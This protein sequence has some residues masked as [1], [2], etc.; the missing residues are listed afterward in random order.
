MEEFNRIIDLL[1][2]P[3]VSGQDLTILQTSVRA[4]VVFLVAIVLVR[5]GDERFMGRH[6]ALDVLL[7]IVFGSVVSRG[8]NGNAPFFATLAASIVLVGVHWT[9]SAIA[10]RSRRFGVLVKGRVYRL[11]KD[12]EIDWNAMRVC[13]ISE[14]DLKEAI[15][16]HGHPDDIA[17]VNAAFLERNGSISIIYSEAKAS[18]KPPD[19]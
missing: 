13:H 10:F 4:V 9:F 14:N 17:K 11:V 18:N 3:D 6:T 16:Q 15:R 2:G 7:G 12:G 1:L 8:I 5:I 19:D